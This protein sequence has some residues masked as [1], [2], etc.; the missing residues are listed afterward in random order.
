MF[1]GRARELGA[2]QRALDAARAGHGASVLVAGEA[3]IGKTRLVSELGARAE[4]FE[5]LLGRC[6]DLVGTELPYQPF[7]EALGG[8]PRARS[9]LAAARVRGDPRGTRRPRRP[10]AGAGGPALGG[11]VDARSRRLPRPQPARPV[12][13]AGRDLPPTSRQPPRACAGGRGRAA[14]GGRACGRARPAG[15]GGARRAAHG[16][17]RRPGADD[18]I[19]ARSEGN[20]FFAEELF[21]AGEGALP[22]GLRELL[23]QRVA[24]LDE[25]T[26][27]L[28]RLTAAAGRDVPYA[29][30]RARQRCPRRRYASRCAR[31]STTAC[32]SAT[33]PPAGSAFAMRCSP[34]RS[35]RRSCPVSARSCTPAW[36]SSSRGARPQRSSRRTGR[37]P[38]APRRR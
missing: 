12:G 6:L 9:E 8:L 7:A 18:A 2:L 33:R 32:S 27:N 24:R 1:V 15:A 37:R 23:L 38:A 30:V 16:A 28:L 3:G 13:A 25:P 31:P 19:V 35:T 11:R 5:V 20:P 10:A 34:K 29:L 21:A 22:R 14:L 17:G 4:G 26:Q 36:P